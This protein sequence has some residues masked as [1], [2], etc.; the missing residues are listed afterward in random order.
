MDKEG[1]KPS[2]IFYHKA[3]IQ[4]AKEGDSVFLAKVLDKMDSDGIFKTSKTYS[5]MIRCMRNNLELERALDTVEEMEKLKLIPS[6]NA[7]LDV[8]ELCVLANESSLA[9]SILRKAELSYEL[10]E[11]QN[12]YYMLSLRCAV[13]SDD[14]KVLKDIWD[15][16]VNKKQ[17]KP[18]LGLCNYAMIVAARLEDPHLAYDILHTI[19]DLGYPYS[20][21][22]FH[23]LLEAFTSTLD[24]KNTFLVFNAMRKAGIIP[25]IATSSS[26]AQKLGTDMN[27]IH[28]AKEALREIENVDIVAF[29]LV[30]HAYAYNG[31]FEESMSTFAMAKELNVIPNIDTLNSLLDACI[32]ARNPDHGVSI[33][34]LFKKN[35]IQPTTAT[36]SKMIVLM[37]TTEHFEDA[38]MYL[39]KIKETGDIP[40]RGSYYRLIKKLAASNDP[41]MPM[42]IEDMKACGYSFSPYLQQYIDDKEELKE[43]RA[44]KRELLASNLPE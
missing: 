28:R 14:Y 34:N 19:Q 35:G 33:L 7:Y 6:L 38:F 20:E 24:M 3:L 31:N 5:I 26:V 21:H 9:Y 8:A 43:K 11:K 29:N 23:C 13:L 17:I 44:R 4:I 25:T 10:T 41:R 22:H 27:A 40:Y 16:C 36:L 39:E 37:C 12:H 32:H 30:I 18:D 15:T 2:R 42:A 1:V